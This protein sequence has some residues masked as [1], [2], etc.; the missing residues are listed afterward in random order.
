MK[1]RIWELDALRGLF[2]LGVIAVHFLFDISYLY[3]LINLQSPLFTF[4]SQW[5][6]TVFLILSGVCVTLGSHP[7]RRG[8]FVFSC[9]MLVTLVTA[10]MYW[11]G[12]QGRTI[13]IYFGVLHCLGICML[14]WPVLKKLPLWGMAILGLALVLSGHLLT[15]V[16]SFPWLVPFGFT[17][18]GFASGDYF[19]LLP[20]LGYFLLGAVV[21]KTLYRNKQTRFPGVDPQN[22][23]I[24][25]LS[26]C[27]RYSLIIYLVHQPLLTGLIWLWVKLF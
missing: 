8:F 12:L 10:I 16:V 6:G 23:V 19:P 1:K 3:G 25:F 26:G 14:L 27:G 7:V 9:G 20:H 17:F 24:R 4:I 5:G 11:T 18:P 22:C 2:L 13:V 21:G 15:R